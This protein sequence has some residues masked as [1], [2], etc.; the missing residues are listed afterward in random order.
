MKPFPINYLQA[1]VLY[2]GHIDMVAS[3]INACL[4]R[5]AQSLKN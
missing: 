5:M 1:F 3:A 4:D 2:L